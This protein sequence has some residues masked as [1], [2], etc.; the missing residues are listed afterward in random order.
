M[1]IRR[2]SANRMSHITNTAG[3][4]NSDNVFWESQCRCMTTN[5]IKFLKLTFSKKFCKKLTFR[6]LSWTHEALLRSVVFATIRMTKGHALHWGRRPF[7]HM[8]KC[9]LLAVPVASQMAKLYF[10]Q[11]LLHLHISEMKTTLHLFFNVILMMVDLDRFKGLEPTTIWSQKCQMGNECI[12]YE[13]RTHLSPCFYDKK[14]GKMKR[15]A[16]LTRL[17]RVFWDPPLIRKSSSS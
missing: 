7:P 11:T 5:D 15:K 16:T 14:A 2:S 17:P 13:N 12:K 6:S 8:C 9:E 1:T 3:L 10:Q 4:W